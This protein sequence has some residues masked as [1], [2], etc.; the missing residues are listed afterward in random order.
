MYV[1]VDDEPAGIALVSLAPGQEPRF[2]L[3]ALARATGLPARGWAAVTGRW[4]RIGPGEDAGRLENDDA[5]RRALERADA[6]VAH[7][8]G[9]GAP[10]WIADAV[11]TADR[12]L[13]FPGDDAPGLPFD[14]GPARTAD[15]YVADAV[16]ASPVAPL[17]AGAATEGL[18]PLRALRTAS[19]GDFWAPATARAARRGQAWPVLLAGE[20]EGR[21]VAVALGEGYWRWAF[22]GDGGRAFYDRFWA[23]VG[24]WLLEPEET[25]A[26]IEPVDRVVS[27]GGAVR[28]RVPRGADSAVVRLER[29]ADEDVREERVAVSD[30]VAGLP[31]VPP[32]HYRYTVTT[33]GET[34]TG[35]ITVSAFTAEYTRPVTVAAKEGR[36]PATRR[37]ATVPL[38]STPWGY[39]AVLVL[40]SVEWVLRRRWGL[41]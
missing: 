11:E 28:W 41:R 24:G 31:G 29:A 16:P 30:G 2:L 22:A 9:D 26:A 7:R 17:M 40:L 14:P 15:W 36:E 6:V 23:A 4:V 37:T 34:G 12:V 32:G 25:A 1:R 8:L 19:A 21:R 13:V 3:P 27:R 38:R 10:R 39:V 5:V 20:T 33:G 35:E 18:P